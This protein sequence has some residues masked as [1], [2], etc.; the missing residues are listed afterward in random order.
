[1]YPDRAEGIFSASQFVLLIY[2]FVWLFLVFVVIYAL[3][4]AIY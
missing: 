1:M 3:E 4:V 2:I